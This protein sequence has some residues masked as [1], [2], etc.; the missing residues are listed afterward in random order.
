MNRIL[1]KQDPQSETLQ[2]KLFSF[3]VKELYCYWLRR[4]RILTHLSL[5][6]SLLMPET[7]EGNMLLC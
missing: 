2:V 1:D 6:I 5:M 4:K 3:R 7:I